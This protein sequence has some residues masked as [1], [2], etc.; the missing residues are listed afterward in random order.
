MKIISWIQTSYEEKCFSKLKELE[1][2]LCLQMLSILFW[3][4]FANCSIRYY[5]L[6]I[7]SKWFFLLFSMPYPNLLDEADNLWY[8]IHFRYYQNK[9]YFHLFTM[10]WYCTCSVL[11]SWPPMT[12]GTSSVWSSYFLIAASRS[13]LSW[14]P[15]K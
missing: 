6:A 11:Y 8:W 3:Y 4:D 7:G 15:G 1:N 2:W 9:L 13:D 5:G 14:L 12:I 10:G